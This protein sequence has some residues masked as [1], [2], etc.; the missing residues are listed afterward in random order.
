[1]GHMS[2]W[3]LSFFFVYVAGNMQKSN[4][5]L[6]IDCNNDGKICN[7][8]MLSKKKSKKIGIK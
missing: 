1:M 8:I 2:D 3:F 7:Q 5:L 6:F 4:L